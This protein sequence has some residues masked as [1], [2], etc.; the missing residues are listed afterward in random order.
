MT[1]NANR[2]N[3]ST[4]G[5]TREKLEEYIFGVMI[6]LGVPANLKGF[7]YIGDA[8]RIT[9]YEPMMGARIVDGLYRR[10][11]DEHATTVQCVEHAIRT[12]LKRVDYLRD[13]SAL[14]KYFNTVECPPP[15]RFIN[16]LA[17]QIRRNYNDD[18]ANR[19]L[20]E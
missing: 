1:I 6:E 18:N 7:K 5:L 4:K 3:N 10:I 16:T 19:T 11:A 20:L 8:I 2:P 15:K 12:A 9:Y 17:D 13:R 14:K